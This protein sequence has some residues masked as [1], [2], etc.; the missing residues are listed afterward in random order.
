MLKICSTGVAVANA[1]DNV[2]A[3]SDHVCESNENDGVA[4]WLE[5]K[6]L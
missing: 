3:V 5:A 1:Y 6:F 4:K 2:K